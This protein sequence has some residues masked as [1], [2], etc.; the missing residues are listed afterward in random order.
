MGRKRSD[1][2][3]DG[4]VA[5]VMTDAV[6]FYFVMY[7]SIAKIGTS[8]NRIGIISKSCLASTSSSAN[9]A[10][11]DSRHNRRLVSK[12]YSVA[13]T[14]AGQVCACKTAATGR[15]ISTLTIVICISRCGRGSKG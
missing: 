9:C 4:G 12:R 11:G 2:V 1:L 13:G 6:I 7:T 3:V 8:R 5:S 10:P 14:K 15:A